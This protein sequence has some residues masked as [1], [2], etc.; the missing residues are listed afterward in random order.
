MG[1]R[2]MQGAVEGGRGGIQSNN[3]NSNSDQKNDNSIDVDSDV[4]SNSVDGFTD[5][6]PASRLPSPFFS[7]LDAPTTEG[8]GQFTGN[9]NA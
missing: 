4:N 9:L 3:G 1:S 2:G 7:G 8:G 5:A 6:P